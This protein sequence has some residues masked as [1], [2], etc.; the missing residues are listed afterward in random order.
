MGSA[1]HANVASTRPRKVQKPEPKYTRFDFFAG[2]LAKEWARLAFFQAIAK[3]SSLS[4]TAFEMPVVVSMVVNPSKK[5][6]KLQ[7]AA[8]KKASVM[9][10]LHTKKPTI[11]EML[12][13]T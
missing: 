9:P 5:K 8:V 1:S 4:L 7:I 12:S 3:T 2:V 10:Q 13:K 11:S 6:A